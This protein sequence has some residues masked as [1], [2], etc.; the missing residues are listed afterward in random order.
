MRPIKVPVQLLI[1]AQQ[2]HYV[3][4]LRFFLLLKM[5]YPQG[6]SKLSWGEMRAI[7]QV[8][9]IKSEKT[10]KSYVRFFEEKGWLRLNTKTGYYLIKSFDRI[11]DENEWRSRSAILMLPFDLYRLKAFIGAGIFAYLHSIYLK[12]QREKES[13]QKKGR[14]CHFLLSGRSRKKAVP[15]SVNGVEKIF[16]ISKAIA[17]RLK[18]AAEKER[19]LKIKKNYS[20]PISKE[21]VRWCLK[22]SGLPQKIVYRRRRHRLQLTDTITPL[23]SFTRRKKMKTL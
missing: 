15:V 12:R 23:F 22:Y 5:M 14:T 18:R 9:R 21:T 7:Q 4:R 13:V 10:M 2:E 16:K 8:L 19:L 11:R 1:S 17:S 20:R 3:S 6:K